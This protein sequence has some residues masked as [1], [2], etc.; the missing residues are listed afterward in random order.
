MLRNEH[1]RRDAPDSFA[2]EAHHDLRIARGCCPLDSNVS[3]EEAKRRATWAGG[4]VRLHSNSPRMW[5]YPLARHMGSGRLYDFLTPR[6]TRAI[7][8]CPLHGRQFALCEVRLLLISR[9]RKR[10]AI[11]H[12]TL[13][14]RDHPKVNENAL[15]PEARNW[16][17]NSRSTTNDGCLIS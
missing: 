4:T 6:L 17:S 8:S 10:F 15:T 13:P 5:R 7:C 3:S 14:H 16:I 11:V 12:S 1:N 2:R 9:I